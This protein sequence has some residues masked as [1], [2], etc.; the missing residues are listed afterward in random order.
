MMS[1][2][3]LPDRPVTWG[4]A[5]AYALRA[6]G[7]TEEAVAAA[8]REWERV[9]AHNLEQQLRRTRRWWRPW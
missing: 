2:P 4:E 3:P 7:L 6:A 8:Q 1:D 9:E 5:L